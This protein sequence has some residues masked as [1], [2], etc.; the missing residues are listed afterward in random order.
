MPDPVERKKRKKK[1]RVLNEIASQ[2]P[3]RT[4]C[5]ERA[6]RLKSVTSL[7]K[8]FCV[9]EPLADLTDSGGNPSA[10]TPSQDTVSD[11]ANRQPLSGLAN[12]SVPV[13]RKNKELIG[14]G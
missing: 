4:T 11:L 13:T 2:H 1:L 6:N 3:M 12:V 9:L 10:T 14:M 5:F 8:D 7:K